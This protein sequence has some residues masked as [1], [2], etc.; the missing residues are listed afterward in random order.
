MKGLVLAAGF[1]LTLLTGTAQAA[2]LYD[3]PPPPRYSGPAY[4]D[5]RYS[6]IYRH[7]DR[8]V[9]PAPVYGTDRYD[10]YTPGPRRAYRG[11]CLPRHVIRDRLIRDGWNDFVLADFNGDVAQVS[12]RRPSGRPF[13]LTVERCSGEIV[14]ARPIRHAG[15]TAYAPPPP[16]RRWDRPSY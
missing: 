16:P 9:P 8:P 4:E 6:D 7:P 13:M 14:D 2:D 11:D 1:G 5:Q 12:A 10:S 3:D 15:P